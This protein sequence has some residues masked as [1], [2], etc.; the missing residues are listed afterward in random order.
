MLSRSWMALLEVKSA[1]LPL[2]GLDSAAWR[3]DV[4]S[5]A[6]KTIRRNHQNTCTL[7]HRE[8]FEP[9]HQDKVGDSTAA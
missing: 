6:G 5:A 9:Q 7:S 8:S 4:M 2:R 1:R 3:S